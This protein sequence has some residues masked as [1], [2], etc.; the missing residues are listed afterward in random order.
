MAL[1]HRNLTTH[2]AALHELCAPT[3]RD[4]T[5]NWLPLYHDMGLIGALLATVAFPGPLV[6]IPPDLF[7]ARPAVWLR[8]IGRHR[9]T[10][11]A[12]PNFAFALCLRRIQT[13]DLTG[14]DLSSW[15]MAINGAEPISPAILRRFAERFGPLG[16]VSSAL[17]PVYGLSEASLA[18]TFSPPRPRPRTLHVAAD[19][20][21]R[22]GKAI[23]KNE[24]E[25]S[26]ELVSV[27]R[28]IPGLELG[29]TFGGGKGSAAEGTGWAGSSSAALR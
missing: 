25:G 11:S 8:A 10:I 26:R 18:V 15:R 28:P 4:V 14:T 12:A 13:D 17:W 21:A 23:A 2:V 5:V 3:A 6:L 16:F 19:A 1:S 29:D 7:L 22:E 20:L 27:G 24:V 9:G